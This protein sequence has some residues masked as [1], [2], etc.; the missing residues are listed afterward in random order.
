MMF[1]SKCGN[2]LKDGMNYCPV[3]GNKVNHEEMNASGNFNPPLNSITPKEEFLGKE[4]RDL[5]T[6]GT[7]MNSTNSEET[8]TSTSVVAGADEN[9]VSSSAE[10]LMAES[11]SVAPATPQSNYVIPSFYQEKDQTDGEATSRE[12]LLKKLG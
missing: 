9:A 7:D 4:N 10:R 12:K 5:P 3:C 2:N 8:F 1:C 6:D 11:D